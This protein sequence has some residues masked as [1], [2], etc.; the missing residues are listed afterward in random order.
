VRAGLPSARRWVLPL[1]AVFCAVALRLA[2]AD[3]QIALHVRTAV[4]GENRAHVQRDL[5]VGEGEAQSDGA[6]YGDERKHPAPSRRQAG[7]HGAPS[8]S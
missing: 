2:L 1:A 3:E 4:G 6:E 5:F 8:G 7:P